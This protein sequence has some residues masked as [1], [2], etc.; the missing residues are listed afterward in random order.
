MDT[1]LSE[2]EKLEQEDK[3]C[4]ICGSIKEDEY[5]LSCN[6]S[7]CYNCVNDWFLIKN[8]KNSF[9]NTDD[10]LLSCPYCKEKIEKIELR[11]NY[12]YIKGVHLNKKSI[13]DKILCNAIVASSGKL[14]TT[15]GKE[16]FGYYC[17][18]HK[19][20]NITKPKNIS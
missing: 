6:H 13:Q 14:C 15:I 4:G 2:F 5:K 3:I 20:F 16:C 17:G 18:R 8:K 12:K 10:L 7:Y 11:K 1:L 9:K 19:K